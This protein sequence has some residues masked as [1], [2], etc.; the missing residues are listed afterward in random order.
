METAYFRVNGK[1]RKFKEIY[2]FDDIW[3]YGML[4]K[5]DGLFGEYYK[6]RHNS[7]Q[8]D[9]I[10]IDANSDEEAINK[11]RE[12]F[13]EWNEEFNNENNEE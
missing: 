9:I 12:M 6:L 2:N 5:Y 7:D 8:Y 13:E 11:V 3:E 1:E 10:D 4:F